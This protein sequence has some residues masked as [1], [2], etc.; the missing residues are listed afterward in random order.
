[1]VAIFV[2]SPSAFWISHVMF[3]CLHAAVSS[4][5]SKSCQRADDLVSGRMKPTLPP[6]VLTS[7]EM[8]GVAAPPVLV[9]V[10]VA[11]EAAVVAVDAAV[12]AGAVVVA[13]LLLL[14]Q[15]VAVMARNPMTAP[16]RMN[17]VCM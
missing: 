5:R 7:T 9:A 14:P 17:L 4:G 1:M 11:V 8:A 16:A 15:A 6:V 12:V 3:A 2:A 13:V 10:V